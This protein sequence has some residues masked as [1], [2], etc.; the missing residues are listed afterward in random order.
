MLAALPLSLPL[1]LN[2]YTPA[3]KRKTDDLPCSVQ[4]ECFWIK[5]VAQL[6]YWVKHEKKWYPVELYDFTYTDEQQRTHT[7]HVWFILT[8]NEDDSTWHTRGANMVNL[9]NKLGLRWWDVADPNYQA[10]QHI[11]TAPELAQISAAPS[12]GPVPMDTITA[13][14]VAP[15]VQAPSNGQSKGG[16]IGLP[17]LIFDGNRAKSD[18]FLDKFLG[19]KLINGESRTFQVPYL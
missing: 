2:T 1:N 7:G 11:I 15:A 19:Y 3:P 18:L 10:G 4:G 16:L 6:G 5:D 17:P 14:V 13:T 9:T 12:V 8:E